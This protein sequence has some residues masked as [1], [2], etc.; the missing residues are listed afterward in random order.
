VEIVYDHCNPVRCRL[1]IARLQEW[2]VADRL[3]AKRAELPSLEVVKKI[4][5]LRGITFE[6]TGRGDYI[7]PSFQAIKLRKR[8]SALR[9]NDLLCPP[10]DKRGLRRHGNIFPRDA[11]V[12]VEGDSIAL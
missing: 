10:V 2:N 3:D 6:L 1:G 7:Q 8:L 5:L 11:I 4:S 9:S 12:L